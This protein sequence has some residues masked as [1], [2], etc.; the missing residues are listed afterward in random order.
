[1]TCQRCNNCNRCACNEKRRNGLCETCY[2]Y[3]RRTGRP[4]PQEL[5]E[6]DRDR[7]LVALHDEDAT[8]KHVGKVLSSAKLG[9]DR[10]RRTSVYRAYDKDKQLLYVGIT[11]QGPGRFTQHAST[12]EWW[13]DVFVLRV[14]HYPTRRQALVREAYLIA[15][16]SPQFNRT[17]PWRKLERNLHRIVGET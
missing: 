1:M 10:D 6:K 12:S 17:G 5:I 8:L 13:D 4:R 3:E 11:Q 16:Y 15:T 2:R 9:P 7:R 14:E